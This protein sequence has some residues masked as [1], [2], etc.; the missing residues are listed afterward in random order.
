M[1]EPHGI[2]FWFDV[3][4]HLLGEDAPFRCRVTM[5]S[6]LRKFA[7]EDPQ[8]LIKMYK[9]EMNEKARLNR[10]RRKW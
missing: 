8:Q 10:E 4:T 6:T 2:R 3:A 9:W 5:A 1:T 7:S